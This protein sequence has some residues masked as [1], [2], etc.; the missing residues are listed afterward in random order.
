MDSNIVVAATGIIGVAVGIAGTYLT[1]KVILERQRKWT[2]EDE[3][4]KIKRELLSKR[5]DILEETMGIMMEQ[6]GGVVA[7][8]MGIAVWEDK[9]RMKEQGIR[10]QSIRGEAWAALVSLDSKELMQ[11]W[12]DIANA[13]WEIDESGT[14]G[15]DSWDK[16]Q[17]AYIELIKLEDAM[18]SQV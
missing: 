6:I 13:Y 8:E 17:K 7:R 5:L 16:A 4:R 10:L 3:G 11:C 9:E 15:K 2:L 18:K 12:R 14:V 1:Q